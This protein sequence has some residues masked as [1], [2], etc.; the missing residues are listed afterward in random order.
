M[1]RRKMTL[2][3]VT[4]AALMAAVL[5]GSVWFAYF[6]GG[7]ASFELPPRREPG[8]LPGESL[9]GISLDGQV[10]KPLTVD[11][12]NVQALLAV[13]ERPPSYSHML[14]CVTYWEGGEVTA[15]HHFARRGELIRLETFQ[16]AQPVQN[17]L[18]SP[19][20]TYVWTGAAIHELMPEGLDAEAL[21]GIPSWEEIISLPSD[22]ILEAELF[23]RS[24]E[25]VLRIQ[26]QETVYAGE[27][28]ISLETGLLIRVSYTDA[29]GALAYEVKQ[30][31]PPVIGD[32]GDDRFTLPDGREPESA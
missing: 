14:D 25:R 22:S 19:G 11:A 23:Y 28:H 29:N 9:P 2:L 15:T 1:N 12:E 30:K 16:G 21:L 32:P 26:T 7:S 10:S 4:A 24:G 3:S 17:H 13:V 18:F 8:S 5:M 27:Y 20:M 31:G 6:S